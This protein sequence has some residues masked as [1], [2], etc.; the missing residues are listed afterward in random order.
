[1]NSILNIL[2]PFLSGYFIGIIISIPPGPAGIE[3]IKRTI[4]KGFRE[5]FIL[6]LGSISAD[7]SYLLFIN[8][9]LL[10]FLGANSNKESL[11]WIISGSLLS[12]IGFTSLHH[13]KLTLIDKN[14]LSSIPFLMGFLITFSNPMTP[15]LWL[16]LSSTIIKRW[17]YISNISYYIFT[18]S[19]IV[20]MVTWFGFLNYFAFKGINLLGK[21]FTCKTSKILNIFIFILG[22][23]FIIFG[24]IHLFY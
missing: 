19:I 20:G 14:I 6:S 24:S 8:A 11:F 1:M 10:K 18:C 12:T 5:G 9:G 23:G 21:N 3:S 16:T 22:V 2:K 7:V 13:K 15:S 4:T 17:Y